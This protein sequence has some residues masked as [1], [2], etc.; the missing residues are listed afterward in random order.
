MKPFLLLQF[1]YI[2]KEIGEGSRRNETRDA[3]SIQSREKKKAFD[4]MFT[5]P[6]EKAKDQGVRSAPRIS[7]YYFIVVVKSFDTI[8][9]TSFLSPF[10]A[11]ILYW[12]V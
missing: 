9:F 4:W 12:S 2:F 8:Q 11:L 3:A 10:V 7:I 5:K 6:V 1:Y